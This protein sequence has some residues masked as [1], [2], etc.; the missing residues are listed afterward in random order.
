MHS[1]IKMNLNGIWCE[2]ME[3]IILGR[4]RDEWRAVVSSVMKVKVKEDAWSFLTVRF[5]GSV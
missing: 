5:T 3:W 1:N 2:C 4:H